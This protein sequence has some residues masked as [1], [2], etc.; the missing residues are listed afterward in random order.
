ML[1]VIENMRSV[2]SV[3]CNEKSVVFNYKLGQ[4]YVFLKM[5][6]LEAVL[7]YKL[8]ATCKHMQNVPSNMDR[9]KVDI[10]Y[11]QSIINVHQMTV[12]CCETGQRGHI[13]RLH[14]S[15]SNTIDVLWFRLIIVLLSCSKE[16]NVLD[17]YHLAHNEII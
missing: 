11:D 2:N 14:H 4:I 13:R 8:Q 5:F 3:K 15:E 9:N 12:K 1:V 7:N 17:L 6:V 16:Q 10:L